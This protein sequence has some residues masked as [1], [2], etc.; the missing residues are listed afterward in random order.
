MVNCPLLNSGKYA[1]VLD[2]YNFSISKAL[3]MV[4]I[5][6]NVPE[7]HCLYFLALFAIT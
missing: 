2:L 6:L 7:V 5:I 3:R 4:M 1:K